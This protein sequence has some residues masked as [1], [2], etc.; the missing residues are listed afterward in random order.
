MDFQSNDEPLWTYFDSQSEHIIN[1]MT[2]EHERAVKKVEGMIE[3]T[4]VR[5]VSWYHSDSARRVCV[6]VTRTT[7][8]TNCSL[9]TALG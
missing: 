4:P 9:P 7:G 2:S 3:G 6:E 5:L 8:V 1:R